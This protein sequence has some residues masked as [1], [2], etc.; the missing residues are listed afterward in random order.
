M[1]LNPALEGRVYP[2]VVFTV[3][4][5]RVERFR[6]AVGGPPHGVPPTFVTVA[7]FEV[8]P[9]IVADVELGMD[10]ARI[11]HGTQEYGFA[12]PLRLGETLTATSRI[13]SIRTRG[14]TSLMTVETELVDADGGRVALGRSTM[15]E[16]ASA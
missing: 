3:D 6:A 4:A 12:R 1:P 9:T 8:F 10:Y 13:V 2:S 7:E 5:E 11:L 14:E 15:I 16:R